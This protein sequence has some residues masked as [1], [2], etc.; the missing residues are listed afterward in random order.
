MKLVESKP[1]MISMPG[2]ALQHR[3]RRTRFAVM[4]R[5]KAAEILAKKAVSSRPVTAFY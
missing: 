4:R 5:R 2:I 3:E 1:V